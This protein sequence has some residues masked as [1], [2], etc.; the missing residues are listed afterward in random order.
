MSWRTRS[1]VAFG[2]ASSL[3]LLAAQTGS[4]ATAT[5]YDGALIE[6]VT[7]SGFVA[8]HTPQPN[9]PA[10]QG[11]QGWVS[12]GIAAL[13]TSDA[14]AVGYY[15][16]RAGTRHSATEHWNGTSWQNISNAAA[17]APSQLTAVT[18]HASNDVWAVGYRYVK[19]G[20]GNAQR[21]FIEHWNGSAWSVIPSPS[22]LAPT[23][24]ANEWLTSVAADRTTDAWAIGQT[25]NPSGFF[26]HWNGQQWSLV[27]SGFPSLAFPAGV[28]ASSPTNAWAA[29]NSLSA[30]GQNPASAV[31]HWNGTTWQQVSALPSGFEGLSVWA[32]TASNVW[33]VAQNQ[34]TDHE[35]IAHWN[36]TA[37]LTTFDEAGYSSDVYWTGISGTTS[38]NVYAVGTLGSDQTIN[39]AAMHWNVTAWSGVN[40]Q[41]PVTA[42]V[43]APNCPYVF[44]TLDSVAAVPGGAFAEGSQGANCPG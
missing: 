25:N 40:A 20:S 5:N 27:R 42:N 35:V 23:D 11:N 44:D 22:S 14:W 2:V 6:Q 39:T 7:S 29:I 26:E 32:H 16:D 1:G 10:V 13:S 4:A 30:N 15:H 37:W 43:Q 31:A 3:V 34:V 41:N 17:P 28:S 24:P 36:G 8:Q 21:G 38:S 9:L 33:L 12:A 18:M 19:Q